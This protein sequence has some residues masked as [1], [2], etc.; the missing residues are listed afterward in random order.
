MVWDVVCCVMCSVIWNGHVECGVVWCGMCYNVTTP[1]FDT[2]HQLILHNTATHF[3]IAPHH[4]SIIPHLIAQHSTSL[5]VTQYRPC[6]APSP[7]HLLHIMRCGVMCHV[8]GNGA[9][10]GMW[11]GVEWDVTHYTTCFAI[12]HHR[13]LHITAAHFYGTATLPVESCA[14]CGGAMW[15]DGAQ[16]GTWCNEQHARCGVVCHVFLWYGM[17]HDVECGVVQDVAWF[18]MGCGMFTMLLHHTLCH[19]VPLHNAHHSH[20]I[21]HHLYVTHYTPCNMC[22]CDVTWY[23]MV[24]VVW[25]GVEWDVTHYTTCFATSHHHI[26]H[27]TAAQF[28]STA[29]L[30]VE[31]CAIC[32]GAMVHDVECYVMS[33]MQDE[34][35]CVMW[36]GVWCGMWLRQ[37]DRL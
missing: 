6:F 23:G 12:S 3:H 10:S 4:S 15:Q 31:S 26:L 14:I 9:W 19:I 35:W 21:P 16:C 13:I 24:H 27:I 11:C 37:T 8:I 28:Y 7:H 2:A 20:I 32:G 29:T 17:A 18:G 25:C 34:V 36:N 22:C 5:H 1:C 33:N 30:P